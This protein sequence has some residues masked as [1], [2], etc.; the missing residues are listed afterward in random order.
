MAKTK[1][2]I[3]N[4]PTSAAPVSV[5]QGRDGTLSDMVYESI[6]SKIVEGEFASGQKLP[7][8][9]D[10]SGQLK[11]SRPVLRQALKQ[12]R[13]DGVITSRQ[14]SG[15]YVTGQPDRAILKFAPV[16]SI[17][18]IQRTFEFRVAIE[19][20]AAFLAAERRNSSQ[21]DALEAAIRDLDRCLKD[22]DL[23]VE[24]DEV[25]HASVCEASDNQYFQAARASMQTNIIT[26]MNLTRNLSLEKSTERLQLV[27][28]E[29]YEILD[30]IKK[31]DANAARRAMR[32]H[33][34][35]A[36]RRVFD[37]ST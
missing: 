28:T 34:E 12:L 2:Q 24:E 31:Q 20:E 8:E 15:S 7:T 21:M 29:H 36:R 33:I 3:E 14:G 25:F 32:T 9:N 5:Q 27:Q 19:S 35:N 23:G 13:V 4:H 17:A 37:G 1:Q 26:G 11:V 10:L 18:D 22:G 6:L 16:G 30:A